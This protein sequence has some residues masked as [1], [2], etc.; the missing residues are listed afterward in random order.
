VPSEDFFQWDLLVYLL[1]PSSYPSDSSSSGYGSMTFRVP[2]GKQRTWT[3][4]P[5]KRS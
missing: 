4:L 5:A 2:M 1:G 3:V